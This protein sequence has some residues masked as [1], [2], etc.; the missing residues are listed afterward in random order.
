MQ[1]EKPRLEYASFWQR[2]NAFFVD[3]IILFPW[4]ALDMWWSMNFHSYFFYFLPLN[5]ALMFFYEIYLVKRFSGTPGKLLTGIVITKY[6]GSRVTWKEAVLRFSIKLSIS[7]LISVAYFIAASN[8]NSNYYNSLT[9]FEQ[10]QIIRRN[11]PSWIYP[12]DEI[13]SVYELVDLIAVVTDKKRRS[14]RDRIAGTVVIK[15]S[16]PNNIQ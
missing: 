6:D 8:I 16:A 9:M 7:F 15:K 10:D 3:R 14:I 5:L 13:I 11:I 12:L 4:A 1:I 2:V